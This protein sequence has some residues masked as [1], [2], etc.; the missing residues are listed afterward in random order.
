MVPVEI[1]LV[2]AALL[3]LSSVM[4]LGVV[5]YRDGAHRAHCR[6]QIALIQNAV[7]SYQHL[8]GMEAGEKITIQDLVKSGCLSPGEYE[9]LEEGGTYVFSENI[10]KEGIPFV[11]CTLGSDEEKGHRMASSKGW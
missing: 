11:R 7:R 1:A 10:P 2:I 5:T 4:G 9:C 6:H 3:G 8:H